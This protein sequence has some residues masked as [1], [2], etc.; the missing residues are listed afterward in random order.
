M[1][2]MKDH[3]QVSLAGESRGP[4]PTDVLNP[5]SSF[6]AGFAAALSN[7]RFR[8]VEVSGDSVKI[9]VECPLS[10]H[11]RRTLTPEEKHA[12]YDRIEQ[13]IE[14]V[15][16]NNFPHS[17]DA[18]RAITA[19]CI[20]K[21]LHPT[22]VNW[23]G[24]YV[25][26]NPDAEVIEVG[27]FHGRKAGCTPL[28]LEQGKRGVCASSLMQGRPIVIQDVHDDKELRKE[29][30][31]THIQ[32]DAGGGKEEDTGSASEMVIVERDE[33]GN[34]IA[35]LDN[36]SLK[37]AA[38][39]NIDLERQKRIVQKYVEPRQGFVSDLHVAHS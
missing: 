32:C 30:I 31:D 25:R 5:G 27:P 33:Q 26:E 1:A 22:G 15:L 20:Y 21:I 16:G 35:V 14:A 8:I 18:R 13:E 39:D 37:R 9:A 11:E 23:T 3:E 29:G 2:S 12:L 34:P 24:Y 28:S 36:D 38:F 4:Q 10:P 7:M 17:I 19:H 6:P